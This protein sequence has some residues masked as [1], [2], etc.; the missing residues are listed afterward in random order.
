MLISLIFMQS[1]IKLY[2]IDLKL[3]QDHL[4]DQHHLN[5]NQLHLLIILLMI[6]FQNMKYQTYLIMLLMILIF[7][8]ELISLKYFIKYYTLLLIY[9]LL[10][11]LFDL[12]C[13]IYPV[14]VYPL[15]DSNLYHKI[16]HY[17]LLLNLNLYHL[18]LY[19]I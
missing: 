16:L 19:L 14:L 12:F 8:Y 15:L 7:F 10:H 17:L 6:L 4:I 2:L 5:H 18:I 13:D 3:K 9:K 11:L 1:V